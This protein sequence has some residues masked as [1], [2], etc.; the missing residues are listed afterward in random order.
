MQDRSRSIRR[1]ERGEEEENKINILDSKVFQAAQ[2]SHLLAT[3]PVQDQPYCSSLK[4]QPRYYGRFVMS[5]KKRKGKR[6]KEIEF[7]DT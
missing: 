1:G 4:H 2:Q 3:H 6:M 5:K 7:E